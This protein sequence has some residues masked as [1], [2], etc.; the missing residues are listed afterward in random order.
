IHSGKSSKEPASVIIE[1]KRP[2]NKFE[3]ISEEKPN[4]KALHELILYYLRER[5][6]HR[7]FEMKH[8]I[9]IN[10]YEWFIIDEN[11]FEN[12]VFRNSKL[13]KDYENWKINGKD[14]KFFYENI[15][16]PHLDSVDEAI[17]CVYVNLKEIRKKIDLNDEQNDSRLIPYYKIL[18]PANLL[19]QPF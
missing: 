7:N 1:V 2:T 6:D 9:I 15:A 14:T 16:K 4:S 17:N 11:W 12:N 18:S 5:I 3:M 19:K 13:K 8:L 10:I